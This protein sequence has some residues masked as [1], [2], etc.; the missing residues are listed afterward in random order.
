MNQIGESIEFKITAY[1]DFA[2]TKKKMKKSNILR[3]HIISN[4]M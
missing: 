3:S 2:F 1:F 4:R